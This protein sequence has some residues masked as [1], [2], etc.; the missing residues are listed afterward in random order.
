MQDPSGEARDGFP[1][2]RYLSFQNEVNE[3]EKDENH[4]HD[5]TGQ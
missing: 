2:I 4:L 3:D 1:A 5:R